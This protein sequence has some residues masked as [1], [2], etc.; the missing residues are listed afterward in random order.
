MK[1]LDMLGGKIEL[2][3]RQ[4]I[5]SNTEAGHVK[6][7]KGGWFIPEVEVGEEINEGQT[8]GRILS[9]LEGFKEKDVL[10][11]PRDGIVHSLNASPVVWPG[12]RVA[13]VDKIVEKIKNLS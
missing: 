11:S 10:E 7:D 5:L 9:I 13:G 2:P 12:T 1:H 4:Y 6:T 8:V 3:R